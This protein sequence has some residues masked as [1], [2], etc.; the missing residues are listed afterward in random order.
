MDKETLK[1]RLL[2]KLDAEIEKYKYAPDYKAILSR[3]RE[4]IV[5]MFKECPDC[6]YCP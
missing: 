6:N 1:Q 5:G 2:A 3:R 4:R